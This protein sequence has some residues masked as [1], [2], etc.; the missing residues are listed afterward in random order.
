MAALLIVAVLATSLA[1]AGNS[2]QGEIQ[3]EAA[4]AVS[5]PGFYLVGSK[6]LE[7]AD[8][9]HSGEMQF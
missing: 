5:A 1:N 4:P 9:N 6:A 2:A 7:S 3:P 8:F